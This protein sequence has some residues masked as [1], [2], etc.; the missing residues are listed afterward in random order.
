MKSDVCSAPAHVRK[1]D[2]IFSRRESVSRSNIFRKNPLCEGFALSS[3]HTPLVRAKTRD[4][5]FP[6]NCFLFTA[7]GTPG[8]VFMATHQP[9]STSPGPVPG[10]RTRTRLPR[11]LSSSGPPVSPWRAE[12]EKKEAWKSHRHR[13]RRVRGFIIP[14]LCRARVC[15]CVLRY[16]RFIRFFAKRYG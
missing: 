10:Y 7:D 11:T 3:F 2:L 4:L 13:R 16:P 5:S 9:P 6:E 14:L 12:S 8:D 15:V 1:I